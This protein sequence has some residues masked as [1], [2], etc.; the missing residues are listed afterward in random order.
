MVRISK[1][2]LIVLMGVVFLLFS[3]RK[4]ENYTDAPFISFKSFTKI[5]NNT[6]I[7]EKGLITFSFTDGRGD[8]GLAASD[9]LAPFN[10]GG[11]YYYNFFIHYFELQKGIWTEVIPP[12]PFNARI[13]VV[14][15]SGKEMPLSGEIE[16]EVFINNQLSVYD[17]IRFEFYIL[18]KGLN[19]S[20]TIATS[21]IIVKKH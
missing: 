8:I 11:P 17:T 15:P 14:N 21:E 1:L 10:P 3:C 19:Q 5:Q 2:Q 13:P 9:T 4:K 7:D 18:D 6:A 12:L 16:M 20:N